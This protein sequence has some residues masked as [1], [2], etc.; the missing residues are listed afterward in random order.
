MAER[1]RFQTQTL[2]SEDYATTEKGAKAM[3]TGGII[4]SVA[5]PAG[6]MVKKYGRRVIKSLG[7]LRKI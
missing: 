1:K 7:K 4:L 6:V 3:K 5:V 2:N